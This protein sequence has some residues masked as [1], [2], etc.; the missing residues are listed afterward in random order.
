MI[1]IP[2]LLTYMRVGLIPLIVL[3]YYL[4]FTWARIAT[5]LLFVLSAAT[6]WLDG[7]LAR[8]W[9]QT[10]KLGAF[11]D[12]VADKLLV[13]AVLVIL[14]DQ[15]QIP[16]LLSIPSIIIIAREILVSALREWMSEIGKR[17]HVDV[18]KV[19]KYKTLL[20][21]VGITFLLCY[22]TDA[23]Y[24]FNHALLWIGMVIFYI[25][26]A[27]TVWSMCVYLK[28]AWTAGLTSISESE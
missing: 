21:M 26:A 28:L 17:S 22:K 24:V 23:T 11:L 25:A 15:I 27:L 12:P 5:V 7:Y 16:L 10:T 8:N 13:A 1:N 14:V 3:F 9:K 4:P 6:D 19:A 2:I 20:Q 18:V